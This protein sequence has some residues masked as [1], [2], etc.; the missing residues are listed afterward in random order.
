MYNT[1]TFGPCVEYSVT[2]SSSTLSPSNQ[3]NLIGL[4]LC[5]FILVSCFCALYGRG[6]F[7]NV[8]KRKHTFDGYHD[9][10]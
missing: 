4:S 10:L 9:I 6:L 2:N 8:R 3:L 1:D 5:V 7:N